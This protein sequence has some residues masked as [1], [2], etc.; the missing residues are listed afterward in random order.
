MRKIEFVEFTA[1]FRISPPHHAPVL[2][3]VSQRG[4]L[5]T[6]CQCHW[7]LSVL[8]TKTRILTKFSGFQPFSSQ[9]HNLRFSLDQLT[10]VTPQH[11]LSP[12]PQHDICQPEQFIEHE[13]LKFSMKISFL[14]NKNSTKADML[15][16]QVPRS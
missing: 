2:F 1:S 3:D 5:I 16:R 14:H 10:S 15:Y 13:I 8:F 4:S 11:H 6:L 9:S 7:C 12:Q